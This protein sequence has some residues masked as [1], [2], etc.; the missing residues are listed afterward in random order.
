[1]HMITIMNPSSQHFKAALTSNRFK[2]FQQPN[3]NWTYEYL[4]PVFSGPDKVVV[5]L[6][7]TRPRFLQVS[8][9]LI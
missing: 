1:M 5:G 9:L 4:A 6:E 3:L 8:H 2:Y 7:S